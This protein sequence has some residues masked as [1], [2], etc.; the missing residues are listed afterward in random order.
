MQFFSSKPKDGPGVVRITY[1]GFV[2]APGGGQTTGLTSKILSQVE[3]AASAQSLIISQLNNNSIR[4]SFGNIIGK[5]KNF[6]L[7]QY[8]GYVE[9]KSQPGKFYHDFSLTH[10]ED[11][12]CHTGGLKKRNSRKRRITKRRSTRRKSNKSRSR[13]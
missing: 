4:D 8:K 10:P 1:C 9:S 12:F 2:K 3:N 6:R 7:G 13:R 11:S 5:N